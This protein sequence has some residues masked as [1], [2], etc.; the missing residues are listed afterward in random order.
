MHLKNLRLLNFKNYEDAYIEF[1][2]KINCIVGDN[3]SGKTNM[4][5]AI[6]YLSL[7]KSAINSIDMLNIRHESNFFTIKGTFNKLGRDHEVF[8]S[9]EKGKKKVFR[10]D[11]SEYEKMSEHIGQFPTVLISPGDNEIIREGN[12]IRRKYFDTILAQI[13]HQYLLNLIGYNHNLRQ[14]NSLLKF[15]R[16]N[17]SA[18]PDLIEP[19]NHILLDLGQK[20]H[21]KRKNFAD[22]YFPVF[23]KKYA[24]IA[25]EKEKTSISYVSQFDEMDYEHTLK[26]ALSYEIENQRTTFGIHKDKWEFMIDGRR[27]KKVGSQGQR[28]TFVIALKLA[29]YD[30]IKDEKGFA[31]VLLLDDIFDKLDDSRIHKLMEMVAADYFSQIFLTDARPE[32][33]NSILS[34]LS[35]E[36]NIVAIKDG[37]IT[38]KW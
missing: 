5:D 23:I 30:I 29:Q 31:P 20:I 6:H 26:S 2:S 37:K 28:K 14:R 4:L 22:R 13:D 9:L 16:D 35:L 25:E 21:Q 10:Q 3:G 36:S 7:T 38:N 12:D 18:D 27:L 17:L 33:T 8:C 24:F 34:S 19:Y 32:R 15:F 11:N 1:T